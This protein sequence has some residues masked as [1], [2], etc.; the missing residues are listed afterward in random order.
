MGRHRWPLSGAAIRRWISLPVWR[1]WPGRPRP[2][3]RVN[4]TRPL[5]WRSRLRGPACAAR[6]KPPLAWAGHASKAWEK[7][8]LHLQHRSPY[9]RQAS[10]RHDPGAAPKT[11]VQYRHRGLRPLSRSCQGHRLY[12]GPG[13]HRQ[14]PG[15]P[16]PQT[17]GHAGSAIAGATDQSAT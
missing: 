9:S 14:D 17:T 4:L 12:R 16:A 2:K 10:C 5:P 8:Q 11:C 1:H 7:H 15:S 3:P 6:P 13:R